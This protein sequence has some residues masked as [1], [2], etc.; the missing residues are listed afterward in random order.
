MPATMRIRSVLKKKKG[1]KCTIFSGEQE[2]GKKHV[3]GKARTRDIEIKWGETQ[4]FLPLVKGSYDERI[5]KRKMY[6]FF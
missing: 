5:E 2:A 6:I 3:N 4:C 1:G